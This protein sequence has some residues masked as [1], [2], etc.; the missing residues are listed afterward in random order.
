MFNPPDDDPLAD[1]ELPPDVMSATFEHAISDNAG[2]LHER[3]H[4]V[5][6]ALTAAVL[7]GAALLTEDRATC[8]I[9]VALVFLHLPFDWPTGQK[10]FWPGGEIHGLRWYYQPLR[11][12][13]IEA[14]TIVAG[15]LLL[16]RAEPRRCKQLLIV[17]AALLASQAVFDS[18]SALRKPS[19]CFD[20][21]SR[22]RAGIEPRTFRGPEASNG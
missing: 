15:F 6:A 9:E 22:S 5:A 21:T 1:F 8:A 14:A 10:L 13:A 19:G 20:R 7:G 16:L 3:G 12:F 11:D 4:A 17:A 18:T 2:H